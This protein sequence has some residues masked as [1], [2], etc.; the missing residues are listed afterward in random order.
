MNG[1]ITLHIINC[2]THCKCEYCTQYRLSGAFPSES[3]IEIF[4]DESGTIIIDCENITFEELQ[5]AV[6]KFKQQ[7]K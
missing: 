7:E 1:E 2:H 4:R 6:E 5:Q 3:Y